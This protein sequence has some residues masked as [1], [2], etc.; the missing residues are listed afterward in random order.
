M[1]EGAGA[2]AGARGLMPE[3]RNLQLLEAREVPAGWLGKNH[4]AWEGAKHAAG[5][6]L[7]FTDAHAELLDGA[8]ARALRIAEEKGA[9]L[10]SFSPEQVTKTWYEKALIPFV[11]SRLAKYFSYDAVN[12][13]K[14]DAAAAN[15]QFLMI[16]RDVYGAIGGH[17][18]VAA[19]VLE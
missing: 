5:R 4:A 2:A 18:A 9:A 17:E 13:E 16:R 15:G 1:R 7:L 6:R 10:V 3:I 8:A 19:D 12:D 14:S 11:Y